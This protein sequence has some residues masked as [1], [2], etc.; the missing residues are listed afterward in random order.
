[1]LFGLPSVLG[2]ALVPPPFE[3]LLDPEPAPPGLLL[4]TP[5]SGVSD[6][7]SPQP[8]T[9][10]PTSRA[11]PRNTP[12]DSCELATERFIARHP[13]RCLSQTK[14]RGTY[15]SHFICDLL[16]QRFSAQRLLSSSSPSSCASSP[17][18][19]T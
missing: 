12:T 6:D 14:R 13:A 17:S 5:I 2:V 11:S 10:F 7:E 16:H 19:C 8:M 18:F 4:A 1:M 15:L 3:L 9:L